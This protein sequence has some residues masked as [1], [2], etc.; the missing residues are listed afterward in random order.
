LAFD[1]ST[2]IRRSDRQL[3]NRYAASEI[4]IGFFPKGG[5]SLFIFFSVLSQ[6]PLSKRKF[7]PALIQIV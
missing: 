5:R 2:P 1:Q 3:Y 4:L 7:K 6:F